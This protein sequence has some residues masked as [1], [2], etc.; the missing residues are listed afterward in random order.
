MSYKCKKCGCEE[1]V[2]SVTLDL[3]AVVD[4]EGSVIEYIGL[5]DAMSNP[6]IGK[7]IKCRKCLTNFAENVPKDIEKIAVDL[8]ELTQ[9][10]LNEVE[11]AIED[12]G[13][14]VWKNEEED[15][16]GLTVEDVKK[17]PILVWDETDWCQ[18]SEWVDYPH[19]TKEEFLEFLKGIEN[20]D[21]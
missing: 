21:N 9:E 15:E 13:M 20:A 16:K 12:A 8:S 7:K 11:Q 10:E 17:Y 2:A 3:E 18:A 5:E 4:S 19:I 1:V 14:H 6:T